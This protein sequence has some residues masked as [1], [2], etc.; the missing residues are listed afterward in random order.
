MIYT[1][2]KE[3]GNNSANNN[4]VSAIRLL[5]HLKL[6]LFPCLGL[7][8]QAAEHILILTKTF[9]KYHFFVFLYLL[10]ILLNFL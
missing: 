3:K 9:V 2:V 1:S 10:L 6:F 5:N 4:Y 8:V 7:T